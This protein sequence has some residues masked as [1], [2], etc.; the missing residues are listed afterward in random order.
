MA[1][2]E[3]HATVASAE[4]ELRS[5]TERLAQAAH[6]AVDTLSSY[7][8]R[9]EERLRDTT[10]LATERSREFMDQVQRYVEDHPLAAVGMAAAVGFAIGMMIRGSNSA[11]EYRS[12]T[13][14]RPEYRT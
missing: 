12:E 14:Q 10:T 6:R 7:G 8:G 1:L 4:R 5:A 11:T 9:A 3:A 13:E 2:E